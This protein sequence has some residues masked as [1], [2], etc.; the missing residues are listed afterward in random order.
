[1]F[2][3]RFNFWR[4][5]PDGDGWAIYGQGS[6]SEDGQHVIPDPGVGIYEF[7]GAMVTQPADTPPA[8]GPPP[9]NPDLECC[10]AGND[11]NPIN[12]FTGLKVE[13]MTDLALA[14]VMPLTLTRTYRPR[15]TIVRPFGIGTTH[16]YAIF[17]WAPSPPN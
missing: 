13:T 16:N 14:D 5:E 8:D 2:R 12:L 6:V 7:T 9:C 11:G 15:D 3:S 4:Y 17:L 1:L 10:D